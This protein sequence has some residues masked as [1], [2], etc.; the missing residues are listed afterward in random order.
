MDASREDRMTP[1]HF[2]S[3]TRRAI[4]DEAGRLLG[5]VDLPPGLPS[6]GPQ[7]PT[8]LL[9]RDPGAFASHVPARSAA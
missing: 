4:L 7:A 5:F 3:A 9:H 8:L 1:I 2:S 6:F